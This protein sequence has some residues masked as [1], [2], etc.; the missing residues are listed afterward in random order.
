MILIYSYVSY[1]TY[2]V[3]RKLTYKAYKE[4]KLMCSYVTYMVHTKLNT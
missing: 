2:V 1:M 3:Q 4:L